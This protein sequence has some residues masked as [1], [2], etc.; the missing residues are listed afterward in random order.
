MEILN[1]TKKQT[2]IGMLRSLTTNESE[3][4]KIDILRKN[5]VLRTI[6]RLKPDYKFTT[7][8]VGSD[9]FIWRIK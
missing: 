6:E 8:T 4:L 5:S 3:C 1:N 7:K 2:L 9:F